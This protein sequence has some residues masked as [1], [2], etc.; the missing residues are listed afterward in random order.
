[1]T[2][3]SGQDTHVNTG[4]T[5]F[6][7][8]RADM[9]LEHLQFLFG[10]ALGG[11]VEITT[12]NTGEKRS[13]HTRFFGVDELEEAAEWAC[14]ANKK[15]GENVYVGAATRQD[16]VFPGK[17][18]T[19]E[20]F[21]KAFCLFADFDDAT[22]FE[23]ARAAYTAAGL[24]PACAVVTGRTPEKRAQIWW[25]LDIPISDASVQRQTLRGIVKAL[26]GDPKVCTPK[27][28]MRLAGT[29]NWPKKE[30][31][32]LELCELHKPSGALQE[33]TLEHI[34]KAF[35]PLAEAE[36]RASDINDVTLAP[37]GSLGLEEKIEDGR[38]G[39]AF[40]LI[41]AHLVELIG[42][43]GCE[44]SVDELYQSAWPVFARK[45]DQV[46][47][48]RGPTFFKQK[49]VYALQAFQRGAIP[50]ARDL[51]EAVQTYAA[52]L[53]G[54]SKPGDPFDDLGEAEAEE[55]NEER[56]RPFPASEL[57]GEPPER[58][59]IVPD[60]IVQGAVNSLYGDGGVGKTLLAQQLGAAVSK[61]AKWL[62][63]PTEKGRVLAI[64][65]EDEKDEI[66]RRHFAIKSSMGFPVGNPFPDLLLWPRV[67]SENVIVR[68]G[69]DG[70]PV[71]TDFYRHL[72]EDVEALSPSLLILD[73]LADI[74][75]GNEI[76]RVQV[77]YFVKTVLGGL[78]KR[79]E[80]R[81]EPLS[82]LLL[83]HP[84]V[85][86]KGDGRGYSGSTA[87]NNSVRSRLYLTKPEEGSQDAR[88][89]TRGKANYAASGGETDVNL[90]F[91]D[92][93]LHAEGVEDDDA[94][95]LWGCMQEACKEVAKAWERGEPFTAR[96]GHAR[97]LYGALPALLVRSGYRP[98]IARRAIRDAVEDERITLSKSNGKSG[99]K[100]AF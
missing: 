78:I 42:V 18:A 80:A 84:S 26:N 41:R 71:L 54:E 85:G 19:D 60:W 15:H 35:P 100:S 92:G 90:F 3:S 73:T 30:G 43:T 2:D 75:G 28:L 68:W 83:G 39:Y 55:A 37:S 25:P 72:I 61:G 67:G 77:N 58:K 51:D 74:Y 34:H 20:D 76:D 48:G 81:G 1:M 36:I 9:A 33:V 29:L 12:L 23:Q 89:L 17:A 66:H 7:Q 31:R 10:R 21:E 98:E 70:V 63:M 14:Q 96:K 4:V 56:S 32:V 79:Q 22:S 95:I 57:V 50:F 59:W 5:P 64:L 53:K 44:P 52:K 86:G 93:V 16:D 91:A 94:S 65:C 13:A 11:K 40:K 97:H 8:P 99:Y 46:R 82:V 49:C 27:Q 47:P 88:V 24:K 69:Q 38:E 87:W 45:V 6:I 62:G